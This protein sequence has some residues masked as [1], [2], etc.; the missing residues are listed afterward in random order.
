MKLF[1]NRK[2]LYSLVSFV[3]FT[4]ISI[5]FAGNADSEE[6]NVKIHFR[7]QS[8]QKSNIDKLKLNHPIRISQADIINHLI[9]LSYKTSFLGSDRERIFSFLAIKKLAPMLAKAFTKVVPGRFIRVEV[10]GNKGLTSFDIFA[11][12]NYL[13]WRFDSIHGEAFFKKNDVRDA[14]IFA[15]NLIPDN[16]QRYFKTRSDK[17]IQKNWVVASVKL[18]IIKSGQEEKIFTGLGADSSSIK[19]DPKLEAKLEH[20]KYLH[21]KNLINDDEYKAQQKKL[22]DKHF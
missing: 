18:P 12:K 3:Y 4:A 19:I 5:C 14:E 1:S 13:N 20:L 22:F 17:R 15:W 7:S 21:S 2:F 6:I 11:F 16:G 8:Y 9:S 10:K